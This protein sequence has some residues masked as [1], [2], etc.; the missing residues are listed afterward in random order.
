MTAFKTSLKLLTPTS[1]SFLLQVSTTGAW[2]AQQLLQGWTRKEKLSY[3]IGHTPAGQVIMHTNTYLD[4]EY[5]LCLD[6]QAPPFHLLCKNLPPLLSRKILCSTIQ[7]LGVGA[8]S[9]E[10]IRKPQNSCQLGLLKEWVFCMESIG[11]WVNWLEWELAS[12][13]ADVEDPG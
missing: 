3:V 4:P 5:S 7:T 8:I 13:S 10:K 9:A 6:L 2:T 12:T 11:L 1:H